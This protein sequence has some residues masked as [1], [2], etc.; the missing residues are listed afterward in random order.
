[1]TDEQLIC[2]ECH[3]PINPASE[4]FWGRDG[5]EWHPTCLASANPIVRGMRRNTPDAFVPPHEY[6][7]AKVGFDK[8]SGI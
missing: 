8:G 6:V 5:G 1:M 7:L 4:Y 3:K 2:A